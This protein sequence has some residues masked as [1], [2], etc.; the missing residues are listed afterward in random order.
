MGG[1]A[2]GVDGGGR[3]GD[4]QWLQALLVPHVGSSRP[5]AVRGGQVQGRAALQKF[6]KDWQLVDG[7]YKPETRGESEGDGVM[8]W[9]LH[10]SLFANIVDYFRLFLH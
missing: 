5:T 6:R 1:V 2:V 3:G 4:P 9:R 8:D 7:G 10:G